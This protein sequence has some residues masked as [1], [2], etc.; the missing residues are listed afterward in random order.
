MQAFEADMAPGSLEAE[1]LAYVCIFA[2]EIDAIEIWYH[3]GES[4]FARVVDA[5]TTLRHKGLLRRRFVDCRE[6]LEPT[7]TGQVLYEAHA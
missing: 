5:T 6:L 7:P 4:D 1:V 3:L 2:D